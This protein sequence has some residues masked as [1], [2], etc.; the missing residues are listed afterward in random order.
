MFLNVSEMLSKYF[1]G[2]SSSTV[3]RSLVALTG[4]GAELKCSAD[5]NQSVIWGF[6]SYNTSRDTDLYF[7]DNISLPFIS[8]YKIEK[9]IRGQHNLVI[10]SVDLDHAGKYQCVT[11]A[12]GSKTFAHL[13]VLGM[14]LRYLYNYA[15]K[16]TLRLPSF[17]STSATNGVVTTPLDLV[18]G[19]KYRIV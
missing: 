8:R 7:G 9:K 17:F 11:I 10:D 15:C 6:T 18:F 2:A 14:Y 12:T 1:C 3:P 4:A 13:N 5:E 19:L 16:F